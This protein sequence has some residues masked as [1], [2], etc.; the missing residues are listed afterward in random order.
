MCLVPHISQEKQG[1]NPW[2]TDSQCTCCGVGPANQSPLPST[3]PPQ[4]LPRTAPP[5]PAGVVCS[6]HVCRVQ[7]VFHE[8]VPAVWQVTLEPTTLQGRHT[9]THK[10]RQQRQRLPCTS[11]PSSKQDA[12]CL[13]TACDSYTLLGN[14][15]WSRLLDC[16]MLGSGE[17]SRVACGS[18]LPNQNPKAWLKQDCAC[19]HVRTA[20]PTPQHTAHAHHVQ[21]QV[22]HPATPTAG[23]QPLSWGRLSHSCAG[24]HTLS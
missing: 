22:M 6:T 24:W 7:H 1:C 12:V 16:S 23:H 11:R 21:S 5:S 19:S 14:P 20:H 8:E 13:V 2:L 10:V 9:L 18:V 3:P 15:C 4:N 17:I